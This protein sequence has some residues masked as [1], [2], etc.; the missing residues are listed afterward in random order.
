L[1]A[2]GLRDVER[3]IAEGQAVRLVEP[4]HHGLHA[5]G[6]AVRVLVRQ[7]QHAAGG[8]IGHQQRARGVDGHEADAAHL[9]G[10]HVDGEAGRY[11]ELGPALRRRAAGQG[12]GEQAEREQT[13][14]RPPPRDHRRDCLYHS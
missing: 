10:E 14:S 13:G 5:V 9:V 7:G 11:L 4:G 2:R 12:R 1:H 3:A 8:G 6:S